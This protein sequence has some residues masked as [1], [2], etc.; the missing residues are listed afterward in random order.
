MLL[1]MVG[2][3]THKTHKRKKREILVLKICHH[4]LMAPPP[5]P[6]PPQKFGITLLFFE[7]KIQQIFK[8]LLKMNAKSTLRWDGYRLLVLQKN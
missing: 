2:S 6:L 3:L 5:S 8:K 7:E 4:L 1:H